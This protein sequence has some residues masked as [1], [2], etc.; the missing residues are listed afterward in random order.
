MCRKWQLTQ[1]NSAN[2]EP[3]SFVNLRECVRV[4]KAPWPFVKVEGS[5]KFPRMHSFIEYQFD[6]R[7]DHFYR[8]LE[9][10]HTVRIQGANSTFSH[11]KVAM[12]SSNSLHFG[13]SL[14][15]KVDNLFNPSSKRHLVKTTF[16]PNTKK[17]LKTRR[18]ITVKATNMHF[19]SL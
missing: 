7:L 5:L 16:A 14:E 8:M 17:W 2:Y 10:T 3:I 13:V 4:N 1:W 19:M 15:L 6:L 11:V 18:E 9:K 12:P